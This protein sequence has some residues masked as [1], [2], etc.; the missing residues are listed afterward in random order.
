MSSVIQLQLL[1]QSIWYD[2]LKRSLI[3]DGTLKGMIERRE[4]LG[5]TSNPSIFENAIKSD[6]DY[7]A[8]LQLMAWG[9]LTSQE[10][11]YRLAIQDIKDAAD[12]FRP[13]Y[14]ASNGAD[15][16]VSLEVNPKLADDTQGTIDEAKW[17]WAEVNR[18]NLMVKIPAT[19]AGLPAITEV[20][21]A[22]VNVNVTL[23]FSRKRYL[24]VMD[25][26]LSGLEKRLESGGDISQIASVASFFVSRLESKGDQRLQRIIDDGGERAKKALMLKGRL[27]VDNTRLAYQSY[28]TFFDSP[29]F[30]I[31]D[32]AGAR[33]QRPL[34]ASTSTK[35]PA[36]DDIKYVESLIAENSI[37][38]VPPE[39]LMAYLDH[40]QPESRITHDLQRAESDFALLDKLGI[41]LDDITQELEDEGVSKF[42][43]SF[44]GLLQAIET[45]RLGFIKGLGSLVEEVTDKVA[46]LNQ[47]SLVSRVY[48][49]DPT[50]WTVTPE[51]KPEVQ[52]RLGWLDLPQK[53]QTW[54]SDVEKFAQ[55][56][57]DDGFTQALVLGM[58]G[59]SLAPETMSL[60]LG[61]KT[62]G[63]AL[64]ILDSTLPEQ[65]SE[66]EA[67]VDYPK[68]LFIVAS[69]SGTTS[70][71]LAMFEYFWDQAERVLGD[72]R[73]SHFIAITDPGS[74]LAALGESLGFRTVFTADPNVGGRYS[75]L[76]HFGLV[77]AALMGVD[78]NTFLAHAQEMAVR[79]SPTRS[80]EMNWG[81]LLGTIIGVNET[82]HRDKLTLLADQA[83]APVSAWLEQLI[84]ESSGKIGRG[85]VPIADEP[86][87]EASA[88]H[89]DRLFVYLR[90]SGELDAFV[91]SLKTVDQPV[92]V[93]N[94]DDVYNLAAQFY[95][96]EFAIAIACSVLGVNAFDQPDVQDSKDRT[97]YKL[98]LY[99]ENGR[100]EEPEV[101]WESTDAKLYGDRFEG[102][103]DCATLTDVIE[104]FTDLANDGDYVAINAYLPRND[105]TQKQL[106]DLRKRIVEKTGLATTLGFGPR[107]LH[108][109]GQLHKGGANNGLFL[110]ITQDDAADLHIPGKS[111]TFGVLA[112]A[113]AL[114]DLEALLARERRVLRI[115]LRADD[116][117]TF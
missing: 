17:L 66:V 63:L 60:I 37:N 100:L 1:G 95:G 116:P 45:Q 113:Q 99:L 94:L 85:I 68:T 51:G 65:V 33:K 18:P 36:Y 6:V 54:V 77:P 91:N 50:V 34:W 105:R 106:T 64:R 10:I 61:K 82:Y 48:R 31:L 87:M 16:Y 24:E 32:E 74:S 115:H 7:A 107:F 39:T 71:P 57:R 42:A 14:E 97:K 43:E 88:Y 27:A 12:L 28:Q 110:Q 8:D 41:S 23:I 76:T 21:A 9:G 83:V 5:V 101:L 40:G 2:N 3:Q 69:K 35:N 75:A 29:R 62:D 102:L 22:G 92:L 30:R 38:T 26:Y 81:A 79:C 67:W 47:T 90:H 11:F 109:T 4:I 55:S 56:C 20:I 49:N 73:G 98:A 58:G 103:E 111:Y 13:Y 25:A 117:L 84:A 52:S 114:G 104:A 53:S 86:L 46:E 59:S 70:E 15:G 19:K 112:R 96:W 78:L 80:L 44:E 72:K 93:L 89:S 108:S